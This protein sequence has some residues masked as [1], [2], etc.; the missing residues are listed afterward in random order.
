M[1]PAMSTV[2]SY[3]DFTDTRITRM[4]EQQ[5]VEWCTND[6][7]AEWVDGEVILMSPVSF[8]HARIA[9]FLLHLVRAYVDE[10]DAGDVVT[11]P[12]QLRFGRLRRRRSPD[13]AFI[14]SARRDQIEATHL[15]G[16]ADLIIEVVSPES[17]TR[18]RR[19][20]FLECQSVGVREYWIV[21]PGS[22]SVEAYSLGRGRKYVPIA[23]L[24]GVVSSNFLG[25]LFIKPEWLWR[26]RLPKV[27]SLLRQ[28]RRKR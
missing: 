6:T 22:R 12:F 5:F 10:D 16:P 28:F 2:R 14:S 21:D 17:Q 19:I 20:K 11:E 23:E 8:Q 26:E 1:N 27:S 4:S 9:A 7:W 24:K 3:P 13:L 18:D 25:G 15:E